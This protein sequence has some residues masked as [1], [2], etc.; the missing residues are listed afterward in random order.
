MKYNFVF[1][2]ANVTKRGYKF[3]KK[4]NIYLELTKIIKNYPVKLDNFFIW[5]PRFNIPTISKCLKLIN[6][7][8]LL[9][10]CHKGVVVVAEWLRRWIVDREI[11]LCGHGLETQCLHVGFREVDVS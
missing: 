3:C 8:Y 5:M 10:H 2:N 11:Q 6:I 4:K 1:Y 7:I 9:L